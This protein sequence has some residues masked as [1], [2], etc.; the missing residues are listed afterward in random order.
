MRQASLITPIFLL[1]FS[2]N[3]GLYKCFVDGKSTFSDRP[4][5]IASEQNKCNIRGEW[6]N[7]SSSK[8][9]DDSQTEQTQA[10]AKRAPRHSA[11]KPKLY[12]AAIEDQ[13]AIVGNVSRKQV[14]AL[15][16]VVRIRGYTCDTVS[17]ASPFLLS[18]GYH[19]YCNRYRYSYEIA[20]KGGRWFVTVD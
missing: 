7:A 13:S 5:V 1:S 16:K 6:L 10:N 3:A 19:L 20:D 2:A 12:S 14:D 15:V 9:L 17:A 11:S 4:C 18:V 8:C